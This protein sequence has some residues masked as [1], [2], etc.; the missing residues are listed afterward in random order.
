MSKDQEAEKQNLYS[1][2]SCSNVWESLGH[3]EE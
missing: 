1:E 3:I 2:K